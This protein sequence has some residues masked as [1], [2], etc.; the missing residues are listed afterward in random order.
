[1][2]RRRDDRCPTRH[3]VQ[4]KSI[5]TYARVICNCDSSDYLGTRSDI[6]MSAY[7]GHAAIG[8]P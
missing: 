4:N 6:H 1:L 3:I 5:R 2:G 8:R 7:P